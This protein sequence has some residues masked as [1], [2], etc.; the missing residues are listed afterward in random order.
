[1]IPGQDPVPVDPGSLPKV[2]FGFP[3]PLRDRL[4]AAVLDGSKT[5]TTG[6]LLDYEHE[7]EPLPRAGDRG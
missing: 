2:E 6:L 7:D 4:V 1:M 3:G 5:S